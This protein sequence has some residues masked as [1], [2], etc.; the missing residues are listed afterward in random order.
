[1]LKLLNRV[2][3]FFKTLLN[4]NNKTNQ[5]MKKG[6]NNNNNP[7]IKLIN[8]SSGF[9]RET[10]KQYAINTPIIYPIFPVLIPL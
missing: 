8:L 7:K 6:L 4:K 2:T 1:M 10:T 9:L 3:P 5:K